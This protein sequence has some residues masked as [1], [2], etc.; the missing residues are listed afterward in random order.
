MLKNEPTPWRD[1]IYYQYTGE[2]THSVAPHDGVRTATRKLVWF[3]STKE[4]NL[5]DLEKDP[6]EMKSVHD[7]PAY[8]GIL[9]GMK[10]TYAKLR[11]EYRV[12]DATVPAQRFQESWWKQRHQQKLKDVA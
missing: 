6:Q 5:F 3:P 4:W 2:N 7:D 1:A 10:E 11:K 8:A 9:A 12:S